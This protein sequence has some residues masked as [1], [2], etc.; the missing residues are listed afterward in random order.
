MASL[1]ALFVSF[2][3]T[4]VLIPPLRKFA[5]RVS[6]VDVPNERKIHIK[7]IPRVGGIGII[8]GS[9]TTY[10]LW[11]WVAK[12][13]IT[14]QVKGIFSGIFILAIIGILDDFFNLNYKIKM[15]GQCL[16][17]TAAII[18]GRGYISNLGVWFYPGEVILPIWIGVPLTFI[19][20]VG[21]TNALNLS[22]GLDGLAGG[23][24]IFIFTSL[25]IISYLDGRIELLVACLSIIGALIAFLRY[26]SFPANVFM[27]DTGSLY[28]GFL[29]AIISI[30]LTQ[31]W[32]SAVA[33]TL[34]LLILGIP[35]MDTIFVFV[36]RISKGRS[37]FQADQKHFHYQFLKIGFSHAYAV[38][39]LYFIQ[40][41]IFLLSIKLRY[42][43]ELWVI[44]A[45]SSVFAFVLGFFF[46]AK[47]SKS[48][49]SGGP[50]LVASKIELSSRPVFNN[51]KHLFLNYCRIVM[52]AGIIWLAIVSPVFDRTFVLFIGV[53]TIVT[54]GSAL[55]RPTYFE[56][57]FRVSI[58]FLVAILLLNSQKT[59][60]YP[61]TSLP[62]IVHRVFWGSI[63]FSVVFYHLFTRFST[64][65]D[66]T[67]DYIILFIVIILPFFPGEI[68]A[69]WNLVTVTGGML[70]FFWASD[71]LLNH[72]KGQVNFFSITCLLAVGI[73]T[74]RFIAGM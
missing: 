34:P 55:F 38:V 70:V 30:S 7:S 48:K 32:D 21:I 40:S 22:D 43:S 3:I 36:A 2:Y 46:L 9:L 15:F 24:S 14:V 57:C 64:L 11:V 45:F 35:V 52:P 59:P 63:A 18:I 60:I 5:K 17:A 23:I 16:A 44:T 68:I 67:L 69:R 71:L 51:M 47:S 39:W 12:C 28:L 65:K 25:A 61:F 54:I 62:Q 72:E 10:M 20:I 53:L 6:L 74:I 26:N 50:K 41:L 37:P 49:F 58:Y 73:L 42:A 66:T 56:F 1:L 13:P 29:A 27:G 8:I 31:D 19:I 4:V 33:R